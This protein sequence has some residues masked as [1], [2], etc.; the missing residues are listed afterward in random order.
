MIA[1]LGTVSMRLYERYEDYRY[2]QQIEHCKSI[3]PDPCP[4]GGVTV[5]IFM[6]SQ[7]DYTIAKEKTI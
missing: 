2:N 3:A 4:L 5:R 6:H 1:C 7:G